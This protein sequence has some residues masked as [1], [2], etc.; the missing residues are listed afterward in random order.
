MSQ[1]R[2][3]IPDDTRSPV[4]SVVAIREIVP[5]DLGLGLCRRAESAVAGFA[6]TGIS[7]MYLRDRPATPRPLN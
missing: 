7:G 5:P 6:G 3:R 4:I 1:G 2:D